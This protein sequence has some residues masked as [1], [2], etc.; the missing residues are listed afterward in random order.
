[1]EV[2]CPVG[3]LPLVMSMPNSADLGS[4]QEYIS[5]TFLHVPTSKPLHGHT[6][7]VPPQRSYGS[8]AE[9]K[10]QCTCALAYLIIQITDLKR[11]QRQ[12]SRP[13]YVV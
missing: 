1:M 2:T 6:G 11:L 3:C 8:E 4:I 13:W 10:M 9:G 5:A 12:T 7:T